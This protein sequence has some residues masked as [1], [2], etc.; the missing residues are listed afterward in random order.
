MTILTILNL[1]YLT[2]LA[3]WYHELLHCRHWKQIFNIFPIYFNVKLWTP[4][5]PQ[6]WSKLFK[7]PCIVI[8]EIRHCRYWD[9][10]SKHVTYIFLH[11]IWT[12]NGAE[13]LVWGS[14]FYQFTIYIIWSCLYS[15]LTNCSIVVL[16]IRIFKHIFYTVSSYLNA[17]N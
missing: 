7:D 3:Y 9:E 11:L 4:M 5:G 14:Q 15:N 1:H 10:Y 2:M 6:Y 16:E 13:V 17:K 12:S 8:S